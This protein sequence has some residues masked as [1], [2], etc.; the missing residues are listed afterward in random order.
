MH[1]GGR[2][3]VEKNGMVWVEE[4]ARRACGSHSWESKTG[5]QASVPKGRP[6]G[7]FSLLA[8]DQ[9]RAT[10]FSRNSS[11]MHQIPAAPTRV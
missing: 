8:D 11:E 10:A 7:R 4:R 1:Q 3:L 5:P 9:V 6:A 2:F